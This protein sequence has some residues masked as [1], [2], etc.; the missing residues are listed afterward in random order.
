[1]ALKTSTI[2]R[3]FLTVVRHPGL[4]TKRSKPGI[5][6]PSEQ[7][8]QIITLGI[9]GAMNKVD[10]IEALQEET[11]LT[12]QQARL[13]VETFFG[14]VSDALTAGDRVELRGLCS[15]FVRNYKPYTGR[16][17]RTGGEV[18]VPPKRLPLFKPGLELKKRVNG[19]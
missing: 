19:R 15:F 2:L 5:V 12:K 6:P 14:K 1:M 7:N 3:S 13:A 9:T 17:P 18:V 4:L 8:N 16:N 11:G 10:L